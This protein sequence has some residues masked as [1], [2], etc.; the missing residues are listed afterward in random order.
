LLEPAQPLRKPSAPS[1]EQRDDPTESNALPAQSHRPAAQCVLNR[2]IGH[3]PSP[4][5]KRSGEA[6]TGNESIMIDCM[7]QFAMSWRSKVRDVM[8]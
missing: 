2:F 4:E 5:Q 3:A 6:R 7:N 8:A 1:T